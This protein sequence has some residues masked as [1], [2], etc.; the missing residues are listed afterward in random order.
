MQRGAGPIAPALPFC[1]N[2]NGVPAHS[3]AEA[4]RA[5]R[6]ERPEIV[7]CGHSRSFYDRDGSVLR[8]LEEA[9]TA[10]ERSLA[11]YVPDGDLWRAT[12]P[13]GYDALRGKLVAVR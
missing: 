3:P 5:I 12:V 11:A 10:L 8:D 1:F 9:Q 6:A 4:Y 13:P 7:I 2:D